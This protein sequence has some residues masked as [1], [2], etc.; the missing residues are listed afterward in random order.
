[1]NKENSPP[2]LRQSAAPV[3]A[4]SEEEKKTSEPV[5]SAR[6][7]KVEPPTM[8]FPPNLTKLSSSNNVPSSMPTAKPNPAAA[9]TT[10]GGKNYTY[11]VGKGNYPNH[12]V[13]ALTARGNWT[14]VGE[15]VAIDTCNFY[16]R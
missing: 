13:K 16:W 3:A 10:G 12:I 8:V 5:N 6:I 4:S 2:G 14:Q 15:D 1:M 11:A 9:Q 7:K